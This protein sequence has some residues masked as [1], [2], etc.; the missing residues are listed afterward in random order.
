MES[1][2]KASASG[3]GRTAVPFMIVLFLLPLIGG[4][5]FFWGVD[6]T[7]AALLW[8]ILILA[9]FA[10][11]LLTH[12]PG[13]TSLFRLRTLWPL[14]F[15]SVWIPVTILFAE[16]FGSAV[17]QGLQWFT[18]LFGG[19]AVL[20]ARPG[21]EDRRRMLHALFLGAVVAGLYAVY[22]KFIGFQS[23]TEIPGLSAMDRQ[24]LSEMHRAFSF[25]PG[26]NVFAGFLAAMG[27]LAV[28]LFLRAESRFTRLG[29]LFGGL[30]L[31][32]ALIL[33]DSRGGW[34]AAF[35]GLF[36]ALAYVGGRRIRL[37]LGILAVFAAIFAGWLFFTPAEDIRNKPRQ[38]RDAMEDMAALGKE[39]ASVDARLGYWKAA[40]HA[41]NAYFLTGAGPGNFSDVCRQYMDLP[42]YTRWPHNVFLRFYAELGFPGLLAFLLCLF[43][44]GRALWKRRRRTETRD[45]DA[46]IALTLLTMLFH[47]SM[48]I[49]FSSPAIFGLFWMLVALLWSRELP[50]TETDREPHGYALKVLGLMILI[51]ALVIAQFLPVLGRNYTEL[52]NEARRG[53]SQQKAMG[54]LEDALGYWPW[55]PLA[56]HLLAR[57][58]IQQVRLT[59]GRRPMENARKFLETAI[60]LNP[61]DPEYYVT[62]ADLFAMENRLD[63][64]LKS[65]ETA[66][67]RFPSSVYYRMEWARAYALKGDLDRSIRI[68][69][70]AL[71]LEPA[72]LSHNNP[73]GMDLVRA[74]FLRA[75]ALN[76]Q[77][78]FEESKAE[79]GRVIALCGKSGLILNSYT[80]R[81]PERIDCESIRKQ[82]E[83]FIHRIERG[84]TV[85]DGGNQ[86]SQENPSE[87]GPK[88]D[89]RLR[90][91]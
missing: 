38:T 20:A 37:G 12:P 41:G 14:W 74:R 21:P 24:L 82:A 45:E 27:P 6:A 87:V 52:A 5:N 9:G 7:T 67:L 76:G 48:D 63:D 62:R 80:S 79:Y 36:A 70:E 89:I 35:L 16:V 91:P 39:D 69:D 32:Y 57:E 40:F 60:R 30:V 44:L 49:D 88:G 56:N 54:L 15:F 31:L 42:N 78:R 28:L 4:G 71:R 8:E 1:Q 59:N 61:F 3:P 84:D 25:F 90:M 34:L 18:L 53:N 17:S 13:K 86:N 10:W 64:A 72:Y 46:L 75:A 22:Q 58:W 77:K 29:V 73:N 51:P 11:I 65:L 85:D 26:P 43:F 68:L 23:A 50:E 19:F 83:E 2:I 33:T 81:H 55:N 47:A 66:S